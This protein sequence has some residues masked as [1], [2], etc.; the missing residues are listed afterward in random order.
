M[1]DWIVRMELIGSS[2]C[3]LSWKLCENGERALVWVYAG[4]DD[5]DFSNKI[6]GNGNLFV[7]LNIHDLN[8]CS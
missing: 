1:G 2:T 3:V 8:H 7:K 4:C 5:V 6:K